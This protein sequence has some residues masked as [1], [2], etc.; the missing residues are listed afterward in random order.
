MYHSPYSTTSCGPLLYTLVYTETSYVNAFLTLDPS[1]GKITVD[2]N[3]H[4]LVGTYIMAWDISYANYVEAIHYVGDPIIGGPG[5]F[6]IEILPCEI[7][8]IV[9]PSDLI[10][11]S[12]YTIGTAF[13]ILE[14][15]AFS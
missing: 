6:N 9:P 1:T 13:E 14:F 12:Q 10:L 11:P 3:Q 7:V 4:S 5:V 8:S 2:A 15:D